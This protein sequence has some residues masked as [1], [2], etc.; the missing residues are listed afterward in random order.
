MVPPVRHRVN[1]IQAV[2]PTRSFGLKLATG[3]GVRTEEDMRGLFVFAVVLAGHVAA[4]PARAE[5][6]GLVLLHGKWGTGLARSPVGRLAAM[7]R[8]DGIRV[9]TPDM[10]WSRTRLYDAGIEGAFGQVDQAVAKLRAAG[11]ARVVVGGHSM[12]ANIALAYAARRT[13]LAGVVAIAPG[14]APEMRG[15]HAIVGAAVAKARRLVAANRGAAIVTVPDLNQGGVRKLP[16]AAAIVLDYFA[17]DGPAVMPRNA[18]ALK[19]GT[20]L[21]WVVAKGDWT[22]R[23]GRAYAYDKAPPDPRSR[24]VTIKRG[25]REAPVNG[26]AEIRAWLRSLAKTR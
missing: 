15:F 26:R 23:W 6:T 21:L 13:R 1:R 7:L 2:A 9:L 4:G 8:A 14:H 20:A 10:P 22:A 17:P 3:N 11:A 18:A 16:M 24:Y 19:P 12:G 5:G 25:H